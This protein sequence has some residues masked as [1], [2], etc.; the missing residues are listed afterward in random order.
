MNKS[1]FILL[2]ILFSLLIPSVVLSGTE[3]VKEYKIVK[4]DTLWDISGKELH[5]S[6]LWPKVWKENPGI[7]NPDRIYPGQTIKI[8]LRLLKGEAREES[9]VAPVVA[10]EAPPVKKKAV[11]AEKKEEPAPVPLTP[12]VGEDLLMSS[13]YIADSV[14]SVGKITGSPEGRN[15]FGS[16]DVVYVS[17]DVPAKVGDEFYI[18]RRGNPVRHPVT[19]KK[20]GYVVLV[21][22]VGRV[23]HFEFGQTMVKITRGF[24]HILTGDLL[25]TYHEMSAPLTAGVFRTPDINGYVVASAHLM[26]GNIDILYIDKGSDDGIEV[27][28]MFTTVAVG[29]HKVPS[30]KI[31]VISSREKTST[32][33]VRDNSLPIAVGN[34]VTGVGSGITR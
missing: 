24:D 20:M 14:Q 12:L 5:D 31:Q 29:S 32:A 16:N 4:G 30:G 2:G 6:F 7:G 13:G 9:A 22:G 1:G 8:P 25:D 26:S 3:E 19:G 10:Q 23:D 34:L 27:G 15:L 11:V 28:D 17:L 18:L 21:L 33:I